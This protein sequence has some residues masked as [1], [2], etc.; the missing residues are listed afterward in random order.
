M[1]VNFVKLWSNLSKHVKPCQ[2]WTDAYLMDIEILVALV[3]M[4]P[5]T[6]HI[7]GVKS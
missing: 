5:P 4:D 7:L 6:Y 1:N 2:R 3:F